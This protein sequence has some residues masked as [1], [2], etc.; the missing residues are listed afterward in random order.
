M[1]QVKTDAPPQLDAKK[2]TKR[3]APIAT[4]AQRSECDMEVD[5]ESDDGL[6]R[7]SLSGETDIACA[8]AAAGT[9]RDSTALL[10]AGPD[11]LQFTSFEESSIGHQ[12]ELFFAPPCVW[13]ACLCLPPTTVC[14]CGVAGTLVRC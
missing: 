11:S 2:R 4:D 14:T 12:G 5:S 9:D 3:P 8:A 1:L 6:H 13:C 10:S 7:V